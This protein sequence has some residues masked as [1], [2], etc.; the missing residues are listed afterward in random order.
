MSLCAC[1]DNCGIP[2]RLLVKIADSGMHIYIHREYAYIY[3]KHIYIYIERESACVERERVS[4]RACADH[5]GIPTRLLVKI[6]D[7]GMHTY[8]HRKRERE[9]V[10]R[11]IM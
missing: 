9:C 6:A 4:V 8:I 7:S 1:N 3:S 5:C 10:W 11:E 2:T